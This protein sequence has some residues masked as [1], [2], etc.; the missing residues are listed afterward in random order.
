MIFI[1]N[2]N[3]FILQKLFIGLGAIISLSTFSTTKNATIMTN[4]IIS[5]ENIVIDSDAGLNRIR[6]ISPRCF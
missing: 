1:E 4:Q 5:M 3:K 6:I 2:E